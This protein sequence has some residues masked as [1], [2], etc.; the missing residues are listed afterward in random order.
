MALSAASFL[1]IEIAGVVPGLRQRI[2]SQ[3]GIGQLMLILAGVGTILALQA[4]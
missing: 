1:Y 2:G 4:P 3:S